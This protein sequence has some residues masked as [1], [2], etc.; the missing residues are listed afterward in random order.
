MQIM[1]YVIQLVIVSKIHHCWLKWKS[2]ESFVGGFYRGLSGYGVF[3]GGLVVIVFVGSWYVYRVI[4]VFIG[5][6]GGHGVL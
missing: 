1:G 4:G 5:V 6:I 2:F 3:I